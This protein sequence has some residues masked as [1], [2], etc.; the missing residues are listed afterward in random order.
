VNDRACREIAETGTWRLSPD[1]KTLTVVTTKGKIG[2]QEYSNL[3][4]LERAEN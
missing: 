3:P 4:L 1:G 2:D